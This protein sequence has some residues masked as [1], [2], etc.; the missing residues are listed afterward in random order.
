MDAIQIDATLLAE[1]GVVLGNS[2]APSIIADSKAVPCNACPERQ[3]C[4][5]ECVA[6]IKY[7]R[8]PSWQ[9]GRGGKGKK[10]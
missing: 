1:P 3:G 7:V 9:R 5:V 8:E 2:L 4:V 10:G 6:F